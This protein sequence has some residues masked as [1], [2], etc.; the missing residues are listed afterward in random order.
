[1][2]STF[3]SSIISVLVLTVL[4]VTYNEWSGRYPDVDIPPCNNHNTIMELFL[5]EQY[6]TN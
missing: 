5:H 1:M 3:P 2:C 6:D 4:V